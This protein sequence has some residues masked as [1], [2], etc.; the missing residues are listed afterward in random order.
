MYIRNRRWRHSSIGQR[1]NTL[2]LRR[3][4]LD[5]IIGDGGDRN[6][7]WELRMSLNIRRRW[8]WF[9]RSGKTINR[10]FHKVLC[11]VLR[12][13]SILFAKVDPVPKDCIDPR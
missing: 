9:Y 8:S 11:S 10:Y 3:D 4:A 12:V 1:V 6:F 13:Q 2:P 7:I 5:N